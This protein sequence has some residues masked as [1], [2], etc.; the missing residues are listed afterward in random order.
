MRVAKRAGWGVTIKKG[1]RIS[2][3]KSRLGGWFGT[4]GMF[5]EFKKVDGARLSKFIT[6]LLSLSNLLH[7]VA[8]HS[9]DRTGALDKDIPPWVSLCREFKSWEVILLR[10][11]LSS[12][13][14]G[15]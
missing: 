9:R 11:M 2:W 5:R 1:K 12:R 13:R 8:D 14:I 10:P 15:L 7:P 3:L 4:T 6:E